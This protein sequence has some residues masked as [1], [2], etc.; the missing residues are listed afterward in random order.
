MENK[1]IRNLEIQ[2]LIEMKINQMVQTFQK[3]DTIKDPK[4][5]YENGKEKKTEH[6][7]DREEQGFI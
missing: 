2:S 4:N 1:R 5:K 6:E 3:N 7:M